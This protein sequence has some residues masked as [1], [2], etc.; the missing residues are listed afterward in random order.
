MQAEALIQSFIEQTRQHLN[1]AAQLSELN[2]D[3]LNWRENQDSWSVLECLEHL[4][5]YGD[6]YLPEM[7]K[8]IGKA[9]KMSAP[10]FSSGM[11][12]GY[13]AKMML[14]KEKLNRMKTFK[15]KNP[16]HTHLDKTV[17]DRFIR[18]Q[19][20]LLELLNRAREVDLSRVRVTTSISRMIRLK[21][22]DTFAFYINHIVRHLRQVERVQ[23][24]MA[25]G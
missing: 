21:L 24:A 19:H 4:N 12:G 18:Q 9:K 5:L 23:A 10:A 3:E 16:I 2:I 6:Y 13:F 8:E 17:I 7:E 1:Q 20:R 14:P 11:L 22:G 25:K 15:D